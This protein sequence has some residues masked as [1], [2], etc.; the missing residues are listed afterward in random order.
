MN[1]KLYS[2]KIRDPRS[3]ANFATEPYVVCHK[4]ND[5]WHIIESAYNLKRA[6]TVRR[7]LATRA[8]LH[9]RGTHDD[10]KVFTKADHKICS[11]IED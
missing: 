5:R 2:E 10:F 9:G 6:N 7:Y 8:T 4:I 1:V 11:S 3:Q